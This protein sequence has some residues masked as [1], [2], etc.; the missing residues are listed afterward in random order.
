VK[1]V[2]SVTAA[3]HAR[4]FLLGVI[5]HICLSQR[6]DTGPRIVSD[7][8]SLLKCVEYSKPQSDAQM[9]QWRGQPFAPSAANYFHSLAPTIVASPKGGA[10]AM[11]RSV[12]EQ[13]IV[14]IHH[15]LA[16]AIVVITGFI[17][18]FVVAMAL[19]LV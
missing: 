12:N 11:N 6:W 5:R 15:D 1:L 14:W 19:A 8:H 17:A 13:A 4:S 9:R 7:A 16:S 10:F 3:A 2:L 18:T